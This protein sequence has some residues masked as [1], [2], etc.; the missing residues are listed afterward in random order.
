M[1][2]HVGLTTKA[3]SIVLIFPVINLVKTGVFHNVKLKN[4]EKN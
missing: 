2:N 4:V 1:E 3:I